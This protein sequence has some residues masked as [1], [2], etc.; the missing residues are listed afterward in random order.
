MSDKR[1][2]IVKWNGQALSPVNAG[3]AEAIDNRFEI[4]EA[5]AIKIV[6]Q[7]SPEQLRYYWA[8]LKALLD[9]GGAPSCHD[10][11][12]IHD[13]IKMELGY[14]EPRVSMHGR[15]F[16]VPKSIAMDKMDQDQMN[17]FVD[18]AWQL[19]AEHW[20][21]DM[22]ALDAGVPSYQE[23]VDRQTTARD[24]RQRRRSL[25]L[26]RGKDPGR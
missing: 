9:S 6:K 14:V 24:I 4:G 17:Y 20:G 25:S 15:M 8:K 1:T 19:I 3:E 13:V 5:V 18:R 12:T 7:R 23:A 10:V 11:E 21:V 22:E 2:F 16:M 26:V